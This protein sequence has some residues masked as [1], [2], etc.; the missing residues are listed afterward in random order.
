MDII[1]TTLEPGK[2]EDLLLAVIKR[3]EKQVRLLFLFF[4][5]ENET[6]WG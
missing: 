2:E 1:F 6:A 5:H 3:L 4:Y